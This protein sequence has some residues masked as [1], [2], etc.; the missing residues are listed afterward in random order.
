MPIYLPEFFSIPVNLLASFPLRVPLQYAESIL[1]SLTIP[2]LSSLL[3]STLSILTSLQRYKSLTKV[4]I[5]WHWKILFW[6]QN[7]IT[8][9]LLIEYYDLHNTNESGFYSSHLREI[10]KLHFILHERRFTFLRPVSG[11]TAQCVK[12]TQTTHVDMP[13]LPFNNGTILLIINLKMKIINPKYSIKE[14]TIWSMYIH[15]S[16]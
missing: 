6:I 15:S 13:I 16:K 3:R 11:W 9:K 14:N 10:T 4:P 2:Q 1:F 8:S 7:S 5:S 12:N